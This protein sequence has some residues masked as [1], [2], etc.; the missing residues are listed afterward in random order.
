MTERATHV[1]RLGLHRD[2]ERHPRPGPVVGGYLVPALGPTAV[3]AS[4]LTTLWV[5]LSGFRLF[6]LSGTSEAEADR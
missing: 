5:G 3:L 6:T 4:V 1:L 2:C